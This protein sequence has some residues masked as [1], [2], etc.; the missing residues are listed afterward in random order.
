MR[1]TRSGYFDL[2]SGRTRGPVAGLLRAGLGVLALLYGV[3]AALRNAWYSTFRRA[4]RRARRPVI[5]IGNLTV[6]G[7]GKT[8]TAVW[9]AR[10]LIGRGL[11]VAILMRGY[12]PRA[13]PDEPR[14]PSVG[15]REASFG[16]TQAGRAESD[17]ARLLARLCPEATVIVDPDRTAAAERAV[18]AGAD[19][20]ILDDGFQHRRLAR[21]LDVVLIDATLPLGFGRLLPRGLLRERPASLRRAD[22]VIVTRSDALDEAGRAELRADLD[23]LSGGKPVL[24][25]RHRAAGFVDLKGRPV[26]EVEADAMQAVLFAGIGRFSAFVR[27]AKGLGVRVLAA[28][29]FPDHHEYTAE[30]MEELPRVA[31]HLDANVLL[32]TEKDAVRLAG[33]WTDGTVPLMALGVEVEF[34]PE[35]DMMLREAI[36]RLVARVDQPDP[37]NS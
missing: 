37:P 11:R 27:T 1:A 3:V 4:A 34:G 18:S 20:L 13:L 19:V 32:T 17:E 2:I 30:E 36:D 35:D 21:D 8:P 16:A 28:Y 12:R 29:E 26:R 6:G 23:R 15:G 10:H 33:R 25:S 31:A 22:L 9:V 24:A 5:S 14:A 7:T